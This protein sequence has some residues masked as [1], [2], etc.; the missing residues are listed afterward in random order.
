MRIGTFY[1]YHLLNSLGFLS[2]IEK[3]DEVLDIGGFDGFLL[4]KINCQS[5]TVIDIDARQIYKGIKY[6]KKDFFKYRFPREY[7]D[8]ILALDVLEHLPLDTERKFFNKIISL[9]RPG[10]TAYITTPSKDIY[11][12]PKI[13]KNWISHC[14]RHQKCLGY[15]KAELGSYL[16]KPPVKYKIIGLSSNAFLNFYIFIRFLKFFTPDFLIN[17]IVKML[18]NYDSKNNDSTSCHGYF[19]T[20]INK[21]WGPPYEQN[22]NLSEIKNMSVRNKQY[23]LVWFTK[24]YEIERWHKRFLSKISYEQTKDCLEEIIAQDDNDLKILEIGCGPG[25]WSKLLYKKAKKLV[26]L[27]ISK[28]MLAQAKLKFPKSKK[29][30]YVEDDF[31]RCKISEK[32]DRIYAI[33]VFEYFPNKFSVVKK[34][35]DLLENGGRVVIVTKNPSPIM[36][37]TSLLCCRFFKNNEKILNFIGSKCRFLNLYSPS[38]QKDWISPQKLGRILKLNHFCNIKILPLVGFF[39]KILPYNLRPWFITESYLVIAEK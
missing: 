9:L 27:D 21:K 29:V 39:P 10:G 6:L 11:I 8:Y 14:W 35:R 5:K 30:F 33:R 19:L 12:F 24:N 17:I 20:I 3:K 37:N 2:L 16:G 4:S 22:E 18:A 25:V 13:L 26:L 1:R 38:I 31:T 23:F 7:Y 28:E 32:F 15:T 34:M 36:K